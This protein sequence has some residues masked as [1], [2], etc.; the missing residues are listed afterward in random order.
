MAS[1][2]ETSPA[3]GE[4]GAPE[5]GK[6]A[7]RTRWAL[8]A[9]SGVALGLGVALAL[10]V[11]DPPREQVVVTA[12]ETVTETETPTTTVVTTTQQVTTT[13]IETTETVTTTEEETRTRTVTT[14][15]TEP[16]G[17]D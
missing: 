15:V 3:P 7:K 5:P 10:I 6:L 8:I 12:R 14:T 2:E 4:D 17:E 1:P 9:L 13:T 16:R 11:A